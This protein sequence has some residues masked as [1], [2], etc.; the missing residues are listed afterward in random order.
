VVTLGARQDG[1][2]LLTASMT[3]LAI[4]VVAPG[5]RASDLAGPP[6]PGALGIPPIVSA[7]DLGPLRQNADI[8][9][10]DGGWSAAW[11][12][13]SI[14]TFG[15]TVL[16]VPGHDGDSWSDNSLSWTMDLD[17]SDGIVLDHDRLDATGAPVEAIP[18]TRK[19]AAFNFLHKGDDCRVQPCNAEYALWPGPV[20]ADPA[21][22]RVFLFYLKIYR[23]IGRLGW[24]QI[25]SGIAVWTTDGGVVR[26]IESPGSPDP[27][28]MFPGG[29]PTFTSGSIV[30]A[31]VLYSYGCEPGFLVQ[32]CK[33]ARVPLAA[34]LE[35][36]AWQFY[37]GDAWS[38]EVTAARAVFQGGAANSVFWAEQ[39]GLF[40]NVYSQPLGD[41]VMYRVAQ[42]PEGPWSDDALAFSGRPGQPGTF[43]YFGLAHPEYAEEDGRTQYVTYV[44]ATGPF[45][46]EFRQVRLV[47][48]EP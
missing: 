11:N 12:G 39:L 2:R 26:P 20:V 7:T 36:D 30:V 17:G 35:R 19:E 38:S 22:N 5:A 3:L 23:I 27:T 18:L 42:A 45:A 1:M 44:R 34:A 15:D 43:D 41:D 31:D 10:R 13:R 37:T 29:G 24:T 32:D 33:V 46:W 4:S 8:R 16:K 40:V 9:G 21:R 47:F 28:L 6:H 25:G 48:G 14:W